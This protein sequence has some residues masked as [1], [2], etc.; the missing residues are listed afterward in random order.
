MN[1]AEISR[2][3]AQDIYALVRTLL[4]NGRRIGYEWVCGSIYGEQGKSCSVHLTGEKAGVWADFATDTDKGDAL[5]LVKAVYRYDTRAALAWAHR[6]LG[7]DDRRRVWRRS[8]TAYRPP[9]PPPP[10][11]PLAVDNPPERWEREGRNSTPI[12]GTLAEVYLA[13]RG[14][15][16]AD[17]YGEVLR[18]AP[19]HPRRNPGTDQLEYHPALI[20]RLHDIHS[21]EPCGL[22]NVYLQA[23]GRDRLRDVKG[24]VLG[25]AV[26]L[27]PYDAVTIGLMLAEGIETAISLWMA[28]LRP[29]WVTAGTTNLAAFPV[30]AGIEA[31]TIACDVDEAAAGEKATAACA[32]RWRGAGREALIIRTAAGDFADLRR[33]S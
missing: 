26:M 16:F 8:A 5:D 3:L 18:F 7:I 31:T 22:Y 20:T 28:G 1:A 25:A 6:W 24:R 17:P 32:A 21:G 15:Y 14:L 11:A 12:A 33:A 13:A 10:S 23:D 2:L 29:C 30:L 19:H 27:D 9:P 4:P